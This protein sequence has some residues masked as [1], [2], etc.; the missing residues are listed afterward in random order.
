M[1]NIS[2]AQGQAFWVAVYTPGYRGISYNTSPNSTFG[3]VSPSQGLA[4]LNPPSIVNTVG[5]LDMWPVICH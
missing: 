3:Y 5:H 2:I 4:A 1:P